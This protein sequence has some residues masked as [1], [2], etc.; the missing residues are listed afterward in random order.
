VRVNQ[1][2]DSDLLRVGF[3]SFWRKERER[4]L[5]DCLEVERERSSNNR[6]GEESGARIS[7]F[8]ELGFRLFAEFGGVWSED[9]A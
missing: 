2:L 7:T 6:V 9:R 4:E 3:R 8:C 1:R 5:S